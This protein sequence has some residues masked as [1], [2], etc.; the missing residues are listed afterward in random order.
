MTSYRQKIRLSARSV[1]TKLRRRARTG[2]AGIKGTAVALAAL[3]M[4]SCTSHIDSFVVDGAAVT[5]ENLATTTPPGPINLDTYCFPEDRILAIKAAEVI[6]A[7]EA[8]KA[9]GAQPPAG[10]IPTAGAQPPAGAK[11][12][13]E[14]VPAFAKANGITKNGTPEGDSGKLKAYR[15]RLQATVIE[16]SDQICGYHQAAIIANSAMINFLSGWTATILSGVSAIMGG[17][18]AKSALSTASALV[19]AGRAEFNAE[20]YQNLFAAAIVKEI[21]NIRKTAKAEIDEKK[22]ELTSDYTVEE[23]LRDANAYHYKCSFYEGVVAVTEDKQARQVLT[24]S[25][26][27]KEIKTLKDENTTLKTDIGEL[28]AKKPA[29]ALLIAQKKQQELFNNTRITYLTALRVSALNP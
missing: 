4:A 5:N 9:A 22:T 17:A 3:A 18:A 7:A 10:T 2:A 21:R 14:C 6:E 20:F 1:P 23:A 13:A 15:D 27:K 11:P 16:R 29:D 8:I 24:R 28:D 12:P 19:N 25:D 26:I